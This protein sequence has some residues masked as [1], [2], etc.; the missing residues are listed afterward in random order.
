MSEVD[1]VAGNMCTAP[2]LMVWP[3]ASTGSEFL[4]GVVWQVTSARRQ[5]LT[6][7][8]IRLNVSTSG[9]IPWVVSEVQ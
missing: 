4:H 6:L 1:D 2:P 3:A 5:G 9:W 7:V 8:H